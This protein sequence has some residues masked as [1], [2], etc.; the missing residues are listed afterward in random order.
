MSGASVVGRGKVKFQVNELGSW[1]NVCTVDETAENE[2]AVI[3][4][5]KCLRRAVPEFVGFSLL[6]HDGHREVIAR[7]RP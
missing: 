5:A 4:A 6:Y 7:V 2:S 1:R 3:E